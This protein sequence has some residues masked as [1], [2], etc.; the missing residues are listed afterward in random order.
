MSAGL[1]L[2]DEAATLAAG[3]RLAEVLAP[4]DAVALFGDLGAGKTTLSRGLLAALGLEEEAPSPTFAIVQPYEPPETRVPVWHIDLY[5]LDS[6]EEADE[7]GL[8]EARDH[9][10]L[11]I[12]WP[13]R[14]ESRLWEDTLRLRLAREGDGRRLTWTLPASWGPRWP[15]P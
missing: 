7:L 2:A 9:A 14:L 1:Y 10:I 11:L 8:D 5:R 3:A 15:F 13:E 4:G 6:P 12:E